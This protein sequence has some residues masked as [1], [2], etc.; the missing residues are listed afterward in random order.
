MKRTRQEKMSEFCLSNSAQFDEMVADLGITDFEDSAAAAAAE[1]V[2]VFPNPSCL[3][4]PT[5][6]YEKLDFNLLYS[7]ISTQELRNAVSTLNCKTSFF[8]PN[9]Q[10]FQIQFGAGCEALKSQNVDQTCVFALCN[11][12]KHLRSEL[13]MVK[14][15]ALFAMLH[16]LHSKVKDEQ[17]NQKRLR[18]AK[19]KAKARSAKLQVE[20]EVKKTLANLVPI[21]LE[22][23]KLEQQQ[24]QLQQHQ[25]QQQHILQQQQ[26]PQ[27]QQQQIQIQQTASVAKSNKKRQP[28]RKAVPVVKIKC[29]EQPDKKKKKNSPEYV[30]G[31]DF[32]DEFFFRG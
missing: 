27:Q 5:F 12:V 15:S 32:E 16:L 14:S 8:D 6:N 19:S 31:S 11:M 23:I 30:E 18:A 25:Q 7:Q 17:D 13:E 24:Q 1:T 3:V 29:P 21:P 28:K 4:P 2:T 20:S 22:Q 9:W 10:E 26:Q